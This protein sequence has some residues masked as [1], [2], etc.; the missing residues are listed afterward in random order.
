VASVLQLLGPS[1][2]GIR[3]HVAWLSGALRERGWD[4]RTAGPAG[5][6]EGLVRQDVDVSVPTGRSALARAARDVDL[7][8]A[9]GL[10]AGW[11]ASTVRECRP[12]VVTVHNLVLD[13]AAGRMAPV[14][15]FLEGRLPRRADAVIAVSDEIGRRFAGATN[16]HVIPPAGPTPE[17]RRAR[18]EVRRDLGVADGERLVVSVARLH[19]QKDLPTLFAAVDGI[20]GTRVVVF[21]EGPDEALLRAAAPA[22]VT[23]AGGRPSVADEMAAADAFVVSSRWESGPLV[24]LEAMSLGRPVVTTDVGFASKVVRDGETGRIVSVGDAAAIRRAI[25]DVLDDPDDAAAMGERGR[26][27]VAATFSADAL[28]GRIE[29]VYRSVL[30]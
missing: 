12:L 2:G 25:T 15:R 23:L 1:T 27:A 3:Q 28:V 8:H 30:A 10:K 24:L 17:V 29:A 19:P 13:E 18:D 22:N 6:L 4:V 14:L 7:V 26:A 5:T 20:E 21:G 16:V 11:M 9:H